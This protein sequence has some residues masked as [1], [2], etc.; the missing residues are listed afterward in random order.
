MTV[1]YRIYSGYRD[2]VCLLSYFVRYGEDKD[3]RILLFT[4]LVG[5]WLWLSAES[6]QL[7][8]SNIHN[9]C[10]LCLG[11]TQW[12]LY[13][14]LTVVALKIEYSVYSTCLYYILILFLKLW[15]YGYGLCSKRRDIG[16][17]WPNQKTHI[18][19][20]PICFRQIPHGFNH[21]CHIWCVQALVQN[22]LR[23]FF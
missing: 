22:F 18:R 23:F 4:P 21:L 1:K 3:E 5:G 16:W 19:V 10:V 15:L 2:I 11:L 8:E 7:P 6:K 9:L 12:T 14:G 17:N 20:F 13:L